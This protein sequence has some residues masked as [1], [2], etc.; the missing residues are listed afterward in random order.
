MTDEI[1][2]GTLLEKLMHIQ[3]MLKAPKGQVNQFGGFNYRSL[4]DILERIKPLLL[5]TDCVVTFSVD[6]IS[7]E[8]SQP[9]RTFVKTTITITDGNEEKSVTAWAEHALNK[10]GMDVSQVTGA[11]SSYARKYAANGLFAIDDNK[12]ADTMD[13]REELHHNG[14]PVKEGM[15]TQDQSIKLDR[16]SRDVKTMAN[17]KKRINTVKDDGYVI[18]ETEAELLI[19]DV[20]VGRQLNMKAPKKVQNELRKK[21]TE[22]EKKDWIKHLDSKGW[23]NL[24]CEQVTTKINNTKESTNGVRTT[25]KA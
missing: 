16:L 19:A 7:F 9:S 10:K 24:H 23:T 20:E 14:F 12:D 15:V 5:E 8:H 25:A 11:T 2:Q 22:L 21:L 3:Q 6:I 4:E 18:S 13:N 17:D 1:M